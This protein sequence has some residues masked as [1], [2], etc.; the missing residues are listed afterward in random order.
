VRIV[1]PLRVIGYWRNELHQE[2]PDPQN[3]VDESWDEDSRYGVA[4][5][6]RT[7]VMPWA[8]IGISPCRLCGQANGSVEYSDGVYVWPEGLAHYVE[9]HAVRLPVEIEQHALARMAQYDEPQR[10][11]SW[12][13]EQ[14][15]K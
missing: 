5:Y 9:D 3:F 1:E 8:M 4:A 13:I 14:T 15:R 10:D 11:Y 7:G 12:W 6:L 2:Y